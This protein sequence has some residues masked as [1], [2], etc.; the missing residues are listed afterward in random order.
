M[1]RRDHE[2]ERQALILRYWQ[3]VEYFTPSKVAKIDPQVNLR[4][5]RDGRPLP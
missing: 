4:S 3:S 1:G 5:V 2:V